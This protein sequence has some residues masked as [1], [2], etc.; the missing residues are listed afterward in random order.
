V[1]TFRAL[2]TVAYCPRKLYYRRRDTNRD[3]PDV[4]S[5]RELAF[6]Y[7]Q[8]LESAPYRDHAPLAVEPETVR[9]RLGDARARFDAWPEL[10]APPA[11]DVLLTGKDCRGVAHKVLEEPLAPSLVF[12][13]SPPETGVWEPQ[14]VRVVAAALALAWERETAIDAGF[15][16]YPAH[17]VIRRI[18]LSAARRGAYRRALTTAASIDDP[19]PRAASDAKCQACE[20]QA[21]CTPTRQSLSSLLGL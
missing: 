18:E 17:G 11:R 5:R 4:S 21:D 19:P 7:D 12:T 16:E 13:G 2:E 8:L 20:Y 14:A 10:V 1:L 3:I 6:E 15:A 9:D